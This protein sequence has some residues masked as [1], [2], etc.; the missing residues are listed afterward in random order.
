MPQTSEAPEN[1]TDPFKFN[2]SVT[3]GMC[4]QDV[5]FFYSCLVGASNPEPP[6]E[7]TDPAAGSGGRDAL[8]E[9]HF[10]PAR[11]AQPHNSA[12]GHLWR[13]D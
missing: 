11:S 10:T 4:V 3:A 9:V 6:M 12:T 2:V 8:S 7:K 1:D 5:L 13:V